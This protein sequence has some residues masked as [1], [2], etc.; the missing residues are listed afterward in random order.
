MT[1]LL[2]NPDFEPEWYVITDGDRQYNKNNQKSHWA[3]VMKKGQKQMMGKRGGLSTNCHT[4]FTAPKQLLSEL[5]TVATQTNNE[6]LANTEAL[7][8]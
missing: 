4:V 3:I 5:P 8:Y 2:N 6:E 7:Y 1:K